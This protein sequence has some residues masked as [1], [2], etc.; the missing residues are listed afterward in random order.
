MILS[1]LTIG[2]LTVKTA[3]SPGEGWGSGDEGSGGTGQ[4]KKKLSPKVALLALMLLSLLAT[5][6]LAIKNTI[7]PSGGGST[8]GWDDDPDGGG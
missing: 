5:G 4:M 7:A 2:G 8:G 1:I 3:I 6:S